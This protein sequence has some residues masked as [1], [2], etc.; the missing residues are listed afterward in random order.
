M[1]IIP[2]GVNPFWYSKKNS[3][4]F[5]TLASYPNVPNLYGPMVKEKV[6]GEIIMKVMIQ[7]PKHRQA[8]TIGVNIFFEAILM[9][10]LKRRK[11]TKF[12]DQKQ[13]HL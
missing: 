9:L 7:M 5:P 4:H 13:L 3:S 12:C 6:S 8:V 11:P 10:Q 1:M 2:N